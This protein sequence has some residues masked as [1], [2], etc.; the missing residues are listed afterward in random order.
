[1]EDDDEDSSS[2]LSSLSESFL[3]ATAR[4]SGQ[5]S[6]L[7]WASSGLRVPVSTMRGKPTVTSGSLRHQ[8]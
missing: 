4:H 1:M 7:G 5:I 6:S 2:L 3:A 8:T